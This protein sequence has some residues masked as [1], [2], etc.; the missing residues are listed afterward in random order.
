MSNRIFCLFFILLSCHLVAQKAVLG[1]VKKEELAEKVY[2]KDTSASAVIIFKKAKTTFTYYEENGFESA[3]E[4]DIKIKIYKKEGFDWANFDIPYYVGYEN[5]NDEYVDIISAYTYNLEGNE[6]IKEKVVSQSKFKKVI[7]EF[8]AK[9]TITFPNVKEGS[10]I[11]LKYRLKSEN[12][13]V[14]PDFQFQY[15]IPVDYAEYESQVPEF[16]IYKGMIRGY[17]KPEVTYNVEPTSQSFNSKID[18]TNVGKVMRYNQIVTKYIAKDI[19]ALR[20]EDYVNSINNYYGK[21]EHELELVRYPDQE[22]KQIATTWENVAKSIYEE[23]RFGKELKETAYFMSDLNL[24]IK[25]DFTKRDRINAVLSFVKTRMNWDEKYGYYTK[26]GVI[27]AYQEKVGNVAE[28]N[29]ILLSMLRMAGVE[30]YPVLISTREN[31]YAQFPNKSIFNY[32]IVN[33]IDE[34]QSLLLDATDKNSDINILPIRDLNW[35]GRVIK[36]DGSSSEIDLMPQ[37]NSK[38]LINIIAQIKPEGQV[39][40]KI[41]QQY[42]DYNAYLYRDKYNG[43]V[44]ESLVDRLE[45]KYKGIEVTDYEVQNNLDLTKPII[46]NYNFTTNNSVEVIGDKI[47]TSPFLFFTLDVNP[48]KQEVREYPVDFGYPHQD[49]YNISLTIPEGYVIETLPTPKAVSMPDGLAN[50]KY[51]I[52]ST[53]KAVQ[54]SYAIDINNAVIGS[55]YYD[56][57]KSFF[58]ELVNKQ[59]EK[60]VLKKI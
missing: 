10:I 29:F 7:N 41:R 48:F 39:E 52:S 23:E 9:K 59:T 11:E 33:V 12:I 51:N 40:G 58:K 49:K 24:L 32:V 47:Y 60:I 37:L 46:E 21:I 22:P 28:I 18:K 54:I 55:E 19:P 27:K 4:F 26:K 34:Q 38:E 57:L 3:T 15:N 35:N 2:A 20:E 53:E 30:A 36:E 6:I 44:K 5:L 25:K 8:W 1:K 42:F 56:A 50:F 45:K 17:V 43:L 16:Y 31:G 13:S 14:L